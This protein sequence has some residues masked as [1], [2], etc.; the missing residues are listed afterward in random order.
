MSRLRRKKVGDPVVARASTPRSQT[1]PQVTASPTDPFGASAAVLITALVVVRWLVPAESAPDGDTLWIVQLWFAAA[2]IWAWGRIRSENWTIRLNMFDAALWLVIAG[3]VISTTTVF[4]HGGNQRAALNMAWEWVGLGVT[5]FLL[6]QTVFGQVDGSTNRIVLIVVT[7]GVVLAGF[8][9]W[10]HYIYYPRAYEEYHGLETELEKLRENPAA[11]DRRIG[12][13]EL[14][15]QSQG[16]PSE[17]AALQQFEGRLR[18][19]NEPFGPFALA[20]TFA[21]LLFVSI[22]LAGELFRTARRPLTTGSATTW[23]AVFLLLVYC[24]VLTKSRTAWIALV[25]GLAFWS[26]CSFLIGKARVGRR[27]LLA[28]TGIL[29][30]VGLMFGLAAIKGGFDIQVLTEAPKSLEYRLQYW[31]GAMGVVREHPVL[32][33]GP[34]NFRQHYLRY[35]VPESSEEIADPHNLILDLWTSGGLLA[36]VGFCGC[37]VSMVAPFLRRRRTEATP[38]N[39][40]QPDD[41]SAWTKVVPGV[42]GGFLLAVLAPVLSA[43]G[44]FDVWTALLFCGW[45]IAFALLRR[46]LGTSRLSVAAFGAASLGLVVHLLG[47]GGIEM[48]AVVQIFLVLAVLIF[49]IAPSRATARES[50][51]FVFAVGGTAIVLFVACLLS[52]T[53]PVL[54]RRALVGS[55]DQA[56]MVDGDVNRAILDFGA[57]ALRDPFSPEPPEKLADAFFARWQSGRSTSSAIDDFAKCQESLEMAIKLDPFNPR[58]YR[59][60]GQLD[61]AKFA[62]SGD[63]HD[64]DAAADALSQAVER[65]PNDS[66]LRAMR[67][68]A[69]SDAGR[70]K[71]AKTEAE[72]ALELDKIN[73]QHGHTDRYLADA[74]VLQLRRLAAAAAN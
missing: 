55:A 26:L 67:A 11:N 21:G 39:S 6:R 71:A 29:A 1:V 17:K 4:W 35:K 33:T 51:K 62:R 8:G 59:R 28:G 68:N 57:A 65:Y 69:L 49:A 31:S 72:R 18:F 66:S 56:M 36:L 58:L 74:T 63:K 25:V 54:N 32:G 37:F 52:A 19:S 27:A 40:P 14:K 24:L 16:I 50:R 45:L 73:R 30:A 34:G 12:E 47:A 23:A 2:A 70:V 43:S 41:P 7:L 64:A 22:I 15:L 13:L 61:L 10:Q 3:H 46:Q 44:V 48:P 53:L 9:I 42:A 60:L 20:N 5:F 38:E